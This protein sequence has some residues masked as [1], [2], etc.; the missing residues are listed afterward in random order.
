MPYPTAKLTMNASS[1]HNVM[2]GFTNA[3]EIFD[4]RVVGGV[5]VLGHDDVEMMRLWIET[6][7]HAQP[8]D[9]TYFTWFPHGFHW[10]VISFWSCLE[11]LIFQT[12]RR[13]G[14]IPRG[15]DLVEVIIMFL[16][17]SN[18]FEINFN[19]LLVFEEKLGMSRQRTRKGARPIPRRIQDINSWGENEIRELR[20]SRNK[21][22]HEAIS[23]SY[24][25][26]VDILVLSMLLEVLLGSNEVFSPSRKCFYNVMR[27]FYRVD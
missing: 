27:E 15:H 8:R 13:A 5:E 17:K 26:L 24:P 23:D 19:Q 20:R 22:S 2:K 4:S 14:V 16:N 7:R 9:S 12:L 21:G 25:D 1:F 18:I 10:L 3:L 6:V 11:K